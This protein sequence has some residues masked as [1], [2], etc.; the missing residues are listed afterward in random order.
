MRASSPL[1]AR[2]RGGDLRQAGLFCFLKNLSEVRMLTTFYSAKNDHR[3][4]TCIPLKTII[5]PIDK[6]LA[7]RAPTIVQLGRVREP[8][9][10]DRA[11]LAS[12]ALL[13]E[14]SPGLQL[15]RERAPGKK[16]NQSCVVRATALKRL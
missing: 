16:K 6:L 5:P 13:P 4:V 11:R 9:R 14:T 3:W 10:E 15:G 8:C 7:V 12:W 2:A 1:C